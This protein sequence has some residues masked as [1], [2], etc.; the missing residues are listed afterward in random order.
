M[1]KG[2]L[3]TSC[4]DKNILSNTKFE[5]L[6]MAKMPMLI[7]WIVRPPS[8]AMKMAAVCSSETSYQPTSKHGVTTQKLNIYR[9]SQWLNTVII[10]TGHYCK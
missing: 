9:L 10:N 4:H 8:S 2:V 5:V 1:I 3:V 6:I 7:F